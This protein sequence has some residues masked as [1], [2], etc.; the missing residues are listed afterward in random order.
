M[1]VLIDPPHAAG[2]GRW[3]SHLASDE[4][5]EELHT[6]ARAAGVPARGF[7]RDH[8][9]V[10]A[11]F[12][13]RMVQLGA[14]PVSSRE[15]VAR[16]T[17]AG[18]RRRKRDALRPRR[19]GVPLA[20]PPLLAPG[21]RVRVVAPAGPA[22]ADRLAAGL[23][24]LRG[25]GLD[26]VAPAP[27]AASD[28]AWLAGD[29][30]ARAAALTDAWLD[31]QARAVWCTRGGF[32]SQRLLDLLDW[33]ALADGAPRWLVGFSDVTALHQAFADQLGIATLHGPGIAGL[34]SADPDTLASLRGLLLEGT[35]RQLSG[36]PAVHG[37]AEGVLVGGNLAV[38]AAMLA[39]PGSRPARG[40]I[41]VLEDVAEAPYR[42]DRLLTQLLRAGW[43][44]GVRGIAGGGFTG[45]GDT[46]R[47]RALLLAR[48]APLG[49]PLVLDLP[50]GHGVTNRALPLGR[51]ARLDATAGT[52]TFGL[53]GSPAE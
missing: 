5:L 7:E 47:V 34:G 37:V 15:L 13:E 11:D 49:V 17:R 43:F 33:R 19:P 28:Q 3:W 12:V 39:T 4:S 46:D 35:A 40:G 36:E 6:F 14:E 53:S 26:A 31:P 22:D 18:L 25:W 45:C 21:D 20:T 1:T 32:G 27:L 8:Y 44:D 42:L 16:L 51:P 48:L 24:V 23:E 30:E 2:H 41:A 9:D 38:L 10:P 50:F 52:L 29:D